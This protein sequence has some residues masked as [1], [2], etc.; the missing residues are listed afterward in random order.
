MKKILNLIL[1]VLVLSLTSCLK[2]SSDNDRGETGGVKEPPKQG[3]VVYNFN[4]SVVLDLSQYVEKYPDLTNVYVGV[5][6]VTGV[7]LSADELRAS[8]DRVVVGAR[9]TASSYNL[10]IT[11]PDGVIRKRLR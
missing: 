5:K 4:P 9:G 6:G 3:P 11:T 2:F 10:V 7:S 8:G 1:V